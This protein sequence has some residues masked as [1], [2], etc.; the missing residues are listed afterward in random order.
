VTVK[1][2]HI[3]CTARS[4]VKRSGDF[5]RLKIEAVLPSSI[6]ESKPKL[7]YIKIDAGNKRLKPQ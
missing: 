2:T 7:I 4:P 6:R 1:V 5:N 3:Q